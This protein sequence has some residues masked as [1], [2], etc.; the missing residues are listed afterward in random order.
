MKGSI[1]HSVFQDNR[2]LIWVSTNV[3][4]NTY[5]GKSA[6]LLNDLKGVKSINGTPNGTIFAASLYG[7]EIYD[8]KGFGTFDMFNDVT[9]SASDSR[10]TI[11]IIQGNGSV[12]YKTISRS[13]F[14]SIILHDLIPANIKAFF[15][16]KDML[17]I[18]TN[19]GILRT[20]EIV[21][22]YQ[23]I[24]LKQVSEITL[25]S[26]VLYCFEGEDIIYI[27]NNEYHLNEFSLETNQLSFIGDLK[28]ALSDKG[29]I[30]AG[31]IFKNEFYFGTEK[32]LFVVRDNK[33]FGV[34]VRK[35]VSCLLK[36]KFQDLIWIGTEG[37]GLYTYSYDQY[38][39]KSYLFSDFSP[40]LSKPATAI[41]LDIEGRLWI[42]T[43][44][45]GVVLIPDYDPDTEITDVFYL[46]DKDGLPDN[47]VY[48]FR[49]SEYG[50]WIGCKS[51][52][53]FYSYET[54]T[55]NKLPDISF[56]NI[57]AIYE[58]GSTLWLASYGEGAVKVDIT[59]K[60]KK[61]EIRAVKLYT[62]GNGDEA[63]NRFSSI[64]VNDED[65]LF[66]NTGKGIYQFVR[67]SL[68]RFRFPE[69]KFNLINQVLPI[70]ETNYIATTDFGTLVFEPA[71]QN[72]NQQ[73]LLSDITTKNVNT[74]NWVQYWLST[75]DGLM[76]YNIWTNTFHYF[77]SSYGLTVS[78]YYNGSTFK[79]SQ[80]KTLFFGGI[81]GFTAIK[82]NYYDEAMDYM[83]ALY[84][85]KLALFGTYR[86]INDFSKKGG[87]S[88]RSDENI[89][90]V[91]FN[92]L[93]YI[94]G[95]NYTYSYK[96]GDG[97]W[98]NNGNSGTISFT[99]IP[100]G[101]YNLSVKYYNNILN[102][103][104]YTHKLSITVLAPWYRSV[105]AYCL[106]F[107]T[108]LLIASLIIYF[109]IKQKKKREEEERIKAEQQRK[110]EIYESK[111][112]FFTD[113][114]HEFC[115]PL[116]LISGP[117]DLILDQKNISPT[118]A[119][120]ATVIDRNAKRMNSLINDLMDFKQMEGGYKLPEITR[121]NVSDITDQVIDAFKI[122]TSG[123]K[124]Q[125][126]KQYNEE[127]IWNSDEKFLTTILINLVSNAVK[128]SNGEPIKAEIS[129]ENDNL[130]IK[131][132]NKGEGISKENMASIFN[133]F[134]VLDNLNEQ[135]KWGQNGLG[136]TITASMVKL[137]SG[138]IKVDSIPGATTVF[139]V[140]LPFIQ[141]ETTEAVKTFD[142]K[143]SV[144]PE[145]VLPQ[146]KYVY[147]DDRPTVT[148][149]DDNPEMLWFICDILSDEFNVLPINDSSNTIEILS[150]NHTDIILCDI[151]MKGI[152]GIDLSKALKSDKSTSHIPLII[153][154]AAHDI[155][156]QTEAI[157]A[158]A[159]LYIA[160]PFNN[161][162]LKTTIKRLLNR[163]EDLKDYFA[164]P[165]SAY[166][167]DL[168]KLQHAEHRKFLKKIHS[169]INK[170]IQN[171]NLSPE[172]I[173][174]ELGTST[175]SLYRKLKEATDKSLL[176]IIRDGKLTVAENLLLK[177]KFTIDEIIFKS[178]F[179][180]RANFYRAFSKKHG[181]TPKEFIEKNNT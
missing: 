111:L 168:G 167:L 80:N 89:F 78:E 101:R 181:C 29:E 53:T 77:D 60:N 136:L 133:R 171:E 141:A 59:Y 134:T 107:L 15:V 85:D 13:E 10:E 161:E 35:G 145:F 143:E 9:F 61:P 62:V 64:T 166:E 174:H 148:I 70:D 165:L 179:S 83:P 120:Y 170:N 139:T 158:G 49:K 124:I 86:D 122:N 71:H 104:S 30:K 22:N 44:G 150:K 128:Y 32:G 19:D 46:S 24:Y 180:N 152:D 47:T 56:K 14:D 146:T 164:S 36:D 130:T 159:E 116:T 58:Q 48:S 162:Y 131:V 72:I 42:G 6:T 110:E 160:K 175:R 151:M 90:S 100:P 65:V 108:V 178:G 94:N 21:Y 155:E 173:A 73:W 17:R 97:Q 39:L 25:T 142:V 34:P 163:K 172:F 126:I 63:S 2:G 129:A 18:L 169:I 23:N 33:A 96:I 93:D 177:S 50:I 109:I 176:E 137:L 119:K 88:F 92:A 132:T 81:N 8:G 54:R 157:N 52:L 4:V 66:I 27:L 99:D 26:P 144:I 12:F 68:I 140:N 156:I 40:A 28:Q 105:Y 102:K 11:F 57:R 82:Y 67:N 87:L 127:I 20:F 43:E 51:G 5:D 106:Y 31:I 114:A 41:C 147:K 69:R 118:V 76:L 112:N 125:I 3:G 135:N 154:S 45:N 74:I 103:E 55:F 79:D 123:S 38:S 1:I 115:T 98:I 95:N 16:Y 75:N 84:L 138:N 91:T 7:L 113:I 149:I 153:V 37:D 121:L 117:C